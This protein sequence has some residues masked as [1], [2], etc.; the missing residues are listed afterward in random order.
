MS[1]MKPIIVFENQTGLAISESDITTG[2]IIINGIEITSVEDW[3]RVIKS[4][5]DLQQENQQLKESPYYKFYRYENNPN[6]SDYCFCQRPCDSNMSLKCFLENGEIL[7]FMSESLVY[8][9]PEIKE[10]DF[11]EFAHNFVKTL[12]KENQQLK[13]VIEEVREYIKDEDWLEDT[14][15]IKYLDKHNLCGIRVFHNKVEDI[16]KILD[17]AKENK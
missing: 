9:C 3:E 16:N 6:G 10:V 12:I 11:D 14:G 15:E 8:K 2:K 4:L 13:E 5:T 7:G 17:K 1:K